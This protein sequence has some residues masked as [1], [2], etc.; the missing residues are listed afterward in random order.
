MSRGL[1]YSKSAADKSITGRCPKV[2][3]CCHAAVVGL[4][5]LEE[6]LQPLKPRSTTREKVTEKARTS[7]KEEKKDPDAAAE[8][9]GRCYDACR[10]MVE[11][12]EIS[13]PGAIRITF[14][15]VAECVRLCADAAG[16]PPPTQDELLKVI[17]T[18]WRAFAYSWKLAGLYKLMFQA[19]EGS[20]A[21]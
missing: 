13:D 12:K 16:L 10:A 1:E 17:D 6:A 5:Q 2:L 9:A 20:R 3:H 4:T 15:E 14:T 8:R 11:L 7:A 21:L 18:K 19:G